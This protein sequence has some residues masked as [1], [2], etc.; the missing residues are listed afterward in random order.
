MM[1][2]DTKHTTYI[3]DLDRELADI[4]TPDG[5]LILLPLAAKLIS[6]PESV[7]STPSQGKELVLYTDPSSL[8]LPEEQ[9]SVRKA[10]IE[11]RARARARTRARAQASSS[12][13]SLPRFDHASS[14]TKGFADTDASLTY[15]T[16]DDPMDIDCNP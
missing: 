15:S 1:L 13:Q 7:L 2:D 6:V 11:S 10:I 4:D 5:G 3:H 8:T 16:D 14:S 12:H 9:D